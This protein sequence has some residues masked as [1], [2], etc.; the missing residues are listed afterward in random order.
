M[1]Q[2]INRLLHIIKLDELNFPSNKIGLKNDWH[3][4]KDNMVKLLTYQV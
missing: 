1:L 3:M 2:L 4:V